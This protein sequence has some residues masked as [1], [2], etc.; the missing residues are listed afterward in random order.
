MFT[1]LMASAPKRR[2][3]SPAAWGVS[4]L[5]HVTAALLLAEGASRMAAGPRVPTVFDR[6]TYVD[7]AQERAREPEP[8][9]AEPAAAPAPPETPPEVTRPDL[10]AGYQVL[11]VPDEV[12]GIPPAGLTEFRAED[13]SGRGVAGGVAGGRPLQL[14]ATTRAAPAAEEAP[15]SVTVVDE[16]PRV[17][18]VATLRS[19]MEA[20]YPVNL[21]FAGIGG[22]VVIQLVVDTKG[23]VE[24]RG[25]TIVSAAF[26][27]LESPTRELVRSL[28][29]EPARRNGRPVRVWVRLPVIWSVE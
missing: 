15:V 10:P 1:N 3:E 22:P 7:I 9:P 23:F 13:F 26:R 27:E 19:R 16:P 4:V 28:R 20:L 5:F 8:K 6:V 14:V 11:S 24:P 12:V 2:R 25:D 21:R 17:I 29:F 18:N